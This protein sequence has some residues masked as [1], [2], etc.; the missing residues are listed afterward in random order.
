MKNRVAVLVLFLILNFTFITSLF[1]DD[2]KFHRVLNTGSYNNNITQDKD[3]LLWIGT[4]GKGLFSYN[5]E[6]IKKIKITDSNN[7]AQIVSSIFVDH[8]SLIW[9]V[10]QGQGLCSYSKETGSCKNYG[11]SPKWKVKLI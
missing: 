9:F 6:E 7:S 10:I 4:E 5:G 1:S 2:I 3:G 11:S 8:D